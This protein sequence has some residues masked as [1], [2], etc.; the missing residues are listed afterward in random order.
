MQVSIIRIYQ[1][2]Q[3]FQQYQ[4]RLSALIG[5]KEAQ[6]RVN[7]ALVLMTLGGNDFVNNYFIPLSPRRRQ[8]SIS[9]FSELVIT[10]YRKILLQL[11]D[12]GARRV[13]VTGTGPLGCVPSELASS[14]SRNGECAPEPQQAAA[15]FNPMLVQMLKGL[16]QELGSDVFVIANAFQMN[17]DFLKNPQQ[18]GFITSKVACC[19]Q[20]AYN[21]MGVCN[22]LSNLCPDRN[23][24]AF[25]DPFHPTERATRLIVKQIMSGSTDYMS[26]MNLSTIM[27]LDSRV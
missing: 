5:E 10:E 15:I 8:F 3:Y 23:V 7:G 11:Y 18:F 13:L 21:G 20:G 26:P 27:A 1:Q 22:V 2:F 6:R 16:N 9:A 17:M 14:G 19:G 25:W 12:L 24:Y 4:L